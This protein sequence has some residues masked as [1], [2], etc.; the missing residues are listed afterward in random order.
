MHFVKINILFDCIKIIMNMHLQTEITSVPCFLPFS[1]WLPSV[2]ALV[3]I[4]IKT[5]VP[6]G[7][8]RQGRTCLCIEKI[9]QS[10]ECLG[11]QL[12]GRKNK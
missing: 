4:G 12:A 2:A 8:S 6:E 5:G 1:L 3:S 9:S 10:S 11:G 7:N